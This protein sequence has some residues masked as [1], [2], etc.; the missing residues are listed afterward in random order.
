MT[1]YTPD[2]LRARWPLKR[3]YTDHCPECGYEGGVH[4]PHCLAAYAHA[5][6]DAWEAQLWRAQAR[7]N[8][9]EADNAWEAER[10]ALE[11]G[12]RRDADKILELM[13]K[14][15]RAEARIEALDLAFGIERNELDDANAA[16][17]ARIEA[18]EK[19]A[20]YGERKLR[21]E[22][23]SEAG[24]ERIISALG[25]IPSNHRSFEAFKKAALAGEEKP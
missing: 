21:D 17:R 13:E 8:T 12:L 9:A 25:R 16:L 22:Y 10:G 23:D 7:C 19:P 4:S 1:N 18:L 15:S 3:E 6:A 24:L 20:E 11:E 14:L 5:H 2:S